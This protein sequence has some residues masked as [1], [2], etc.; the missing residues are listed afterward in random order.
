MNKQRY[1]VT[2]TG[3]DDYTSFVTELTL[4]EFETVRS[5]AELSKIHS[6]VSCQPILEIVEAVDGDDE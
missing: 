1:Y 6:Y 5:I 4:S 3:C 2:L